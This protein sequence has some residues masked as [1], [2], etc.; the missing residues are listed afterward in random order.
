MLA[1]PLLFALAGPVHPPASVEH[2]LIVR[3]NSSQHTVTLIGGQYD[4]APATDE[5]PGM[6]MGMMKMQSSSLLRFTWPV[7]GWV[8]G[9]RLRIVDADGKP[10]SRKLVHHINVVNFGRR[11]LFYAIPERM[12]AMGEETEDIRV[13]A[14]VGIPVTTGMPMAALVMWHNHSANMIKGVSFEMTVEYSPTN[15]VPKP[16]SVLPVYL[17]VMNPV[18]Q[19]VDFDL[20]AGH[21]SWHRDFSLP[22]SGRIIGAGGHAHDFATGLMLQ[23][24]TDSSKPK[25]VVNLQIKLAPKGYI[26]SVERTLPGI[27][28]DGIR[29]QDSHRYRLVGT[30]NNPTGKSIEKGAMLHMAL[31]YV[32]DHPDRWPAL[33]TGDADWK[34]DVARLVGMGEIPQQKE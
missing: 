33:N 20:P 13:P 28:G 30:Y 11:Q 6:P 18:G 23:D 12:I 7:T 2:G 17:D 24:V 14:T 4:I 29:L 31:L 8:R 15:L 10:L 25:Q 16:V 21:T 34:K 1:L 5:M 32:P 9:V 3:V 19:D 26:E 27:T 22:L